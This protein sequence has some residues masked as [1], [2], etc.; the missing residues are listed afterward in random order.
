[1]CSYLYSSTVCFRL[2]ESR[3]GR[4]ENEYVFVGLGSD[5]NNPTVVHSLMKHALWLSFISI[6]LGGM[7]LEAGSRG[8]G[9]GH[10]AA[11]PLLTAPAALGYEPSVTRCTSH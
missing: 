3:R 2:Y 7:R 9:G 5:I 4:T 1:M 10:T 6:T 8:G 11:S